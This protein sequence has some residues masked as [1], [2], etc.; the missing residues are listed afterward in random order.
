MDGFC[1]ALVNHALKPKQN[2]YDLHVEFLLV[3]NETM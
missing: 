2:Y 1:Y 3:K